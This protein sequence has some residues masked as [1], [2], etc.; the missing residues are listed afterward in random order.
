MK[1]SRRQLLSHAAA[2]FA[3]PALAQ[4]MM[5]EE[6]SGSS[7]TSSPLPAKIKRVI[8]LF[9]YGG[10][11]SIDTFDYKPQLARD[12]GKPLPFE[13]PRVQFRDTKNLF[14]S[15]WKF[16]QYG[17]SGTWVSELFPHV[18]RHVD[19]LTFVHSLY[20][21]NAAHGGALLKIHTGSDTFVRPSM[22][23][24]ISYG[25][26]TENSN[27]PAFVTIDPTLNHGGVQNFGAS[28]LPAQHQGVRVH[29]KV[30]T[31]NDLVPSSPVAVQAKK[32][33]LLRRLNRQQFADA[34]PEL[35]LD[36]RIKSFEL[37][38]RL[39]REAPEA[40]DL[41]SESQTTHALYGTDSERTAAF[42]RQCLLARRLAERGVRFIQ[43][44][45]REGES[46]T[47][48]DHSNLVK[49]HPKLAEAVDKPI[50]GLLTDLQQRGL[51][52]DT[53]VMWGG[54]FGRTPTAEGN[55]G[56]DHNPHG[57][58]WWLAGGGLKPGV[59][60][61]A[62]DEYGYYAVQDRVHIHDL[63]ATLLYLMGLDH[64]QLT[65]R[66]SGR[67]FRLTDVHGRVVREILS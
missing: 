8:F 15:P 17:D 41:G 50:A 55:D 35:S 63:H 49:H 45:H 3:M 2:G 65:Y 1:P 22:G 21:S 64:E 39:Q 23:A 34:G 18:T 56:R 44:T 54:E 40:I 58:T 19:R 33:A 61:G 37:A 32:L 52:E 47:W 59:H 28:F 25:L 13:K 16:R 5:N 48:D 20:G 9:M 36:A 67:D 6:V 4:L 11:S 51:L 66:Y 24:W 27:L 46:I 10:P 30:A 7:A 14:R 43:C 60:F 42:G 62:T 29:G 12:H 38:F 31:I 26:G 53:L 57:F